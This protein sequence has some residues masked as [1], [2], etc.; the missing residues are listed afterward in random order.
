MKIRNGFVSNSSSSS[1]IIAGKKAPRMTIDVDISSLVEYTIN[2]KVELD[3]YFIDQYCYESI[4]EMKS[5]DKWVSDNYDNCLKELDKGNT[6][7]AGE[8]S[9]DDDD[10]YSSLI[11]YGGFKGKTNFKIIEG[12]K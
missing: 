2:N 10:Q 1:F 7:Y 11:Y 4:E 8:V 3:E 5:E 12:E 9:S 6:I